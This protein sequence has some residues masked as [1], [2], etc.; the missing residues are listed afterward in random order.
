M[1]YGAAAVSDFYLKDMPEH[2]IQSTEGGRR[3]NKE[4]GGGGK[5]FKME[6]DEVP[7]MLGEVKGWCPG[8]FLCG[9]KLETDETILTSK[10]ERKG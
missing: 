2:K 7:K 1:Y 5:G 4:E 3:V 8:V 6:L 10:V 9:F